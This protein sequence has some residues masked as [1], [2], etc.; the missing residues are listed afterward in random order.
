MDRK[1]FTVDEE[2]KRYLKDLARYFDSNA[3]EQMREAVADRWAK[4]FVDANRPTAEATQ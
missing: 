2:T 4:V 3:S 1:L